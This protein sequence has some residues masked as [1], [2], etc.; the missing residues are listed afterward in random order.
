M[1]SF[2]FLIQ[3]MCN[4]QNN[5]NN[6]NIIKYPEQKKKNTEHEWFE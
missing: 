1:F 6:N 4:T 2:L 5:Q 3:R